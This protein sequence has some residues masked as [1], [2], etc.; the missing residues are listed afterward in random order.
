MI[1]RKAANRTAAIFTLAFVAFVGLTISAF[2]A[3][4]VLESSVP[5]DN[6]S[7]TRSYTTDVLPTLSINST[8]TM[9]GTRLVANV[10]NYAGFNASAAFNFTYP[11]GTTNL[12]LY[13]GASL[14]DDTLLVIRINSHLVLTTIIV[15]A[16]TAIDLSTFNLYL[17]PGST[18]IDLT[19]LN[20]DHSTTETKWIYLDPSISI[21]RSTIENLQT[22]DGTCFL[23]I[24]DDGFTSVSVS[25]P[26]GSDTCTVTKFPENQVYSAGIATI[27][28]HV[29]FSSIVPP[30]KYQL[31]F[32]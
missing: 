19:F 9:D 31:V 15:P 27:G 11:Q 26:L 17:S 20:D 32:S 18:S 13:L 12:T 16:L 21:E 4:A 28:S 25:L 14:P 30:S 29:V 6:V 3:N 10:T 1:S 7:V 2:V 24:L 23:D 5:K 8:F 22:R